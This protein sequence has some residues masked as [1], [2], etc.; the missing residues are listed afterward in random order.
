MKVVGSLLQQT[1]PADA[2]EIVI[3]D[4]AST[5]HTREYVEGILKDTT[6]NIRYVYEANLGV[7]QARNSGMQNTSGEI[8]AYIDDD[9]VAD[10][11]WLARLVEA[12]K[13]DNSI[14]CVAGKVDLL[15]EVPEPDWM[16]RELYGYLGD[17]TSWGN[18]P[19]ELP[20]DRNP[21]EGNMALRMWAVQEAGGFDTHFGRVGRTLSTGEG[22]RLA[23]QLRP[24]GKILY[25]PEAVVHHCVPAW[26]A[27]KEYLIK[28]GFMQG[29]ANANL[30]FLRDPRS[31]AGLI[32]SLLSNIWFL[33]KE[34]MG[35]IKNWLQ[36]D[37]R[38][39]FAYRVF[40][41]IRL[42]QMW[43]TLRLALGFVRFD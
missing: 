23:D 7:S 42:G 14:V 33:I 8:L 17:N 12:M 28:L 6:H 38:K 36:R 35:M 22:T 4:N 10:P 39:T 41:I 43:Q 13:G 1:Y 11:G 32:R 34:N 31:R 3:V 18:L 27:K 5:D 26:R 16:P 2:F 40:T 29:I 9:A 21:H 20:V 19:R 24:L 25:T 37:S 30:N 15:W